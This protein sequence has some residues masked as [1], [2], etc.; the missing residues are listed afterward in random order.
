MCRCDTIIWLDLPRWRVWSQVVLRSFRRIVTRE[1]LAHGNRETPR[2]LFSCRGP[3]WWS[4]KTFTQRR[5][6]YSAMFA[7]P[8]NAGRRLIRLRSRDEVDR[9]LA[10]V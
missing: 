7:D 10:A 6:D 5:R 4:V 2:M 3:V 9:M 1:E 8:S